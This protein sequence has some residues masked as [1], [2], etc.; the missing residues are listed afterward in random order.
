MSK[1]KRKKEECKSQVACWKVRTMQDSE[2]RPQ[3]RSTLVTRELARL[4][5]DI[6][7]SQRSKLCG[8]RLPH[9]RWSRLHPLLVWEEQGRT[10]PLWCRFHDQNFPATKLLNLP[11]GHSDRLMSLGPPTKTTSLPLSSVCTRQLCWLKLE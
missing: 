2:D 9:G 3:R 7:C 8:T 1:K 6:T 11:I 5:I 10:P 4:D